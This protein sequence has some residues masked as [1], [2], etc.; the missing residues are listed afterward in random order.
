MREHEIMVRLNDAELARLDE[1]RPTGTARAVLS[2]TGFHG[3]RVS[4]FLLSLR[5]RSIDPSGER[6][7]PQTLRVEYR[8]GTRADGRC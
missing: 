8:Q 1:T 7:G 3:D 5:G 6:R 2:R 4:W